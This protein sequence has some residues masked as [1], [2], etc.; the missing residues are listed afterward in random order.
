[1]FHHVH[2]RARGGGNLHSGFREVVVVVER[3]TTV[4]GVNIVN[5][6]EVER[7]AKSNRGYND[8]YL[9]RQTREDMSY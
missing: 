9:K 3:V 8:I 5:R 2:A 6:V 1:L 4:V 7:K